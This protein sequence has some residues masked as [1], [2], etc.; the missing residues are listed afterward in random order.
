MIAE[1]RGQ[2]SDVRCQMS[3]VR[4]QRSEVRGQRSEVRGQ[5]SEARGQK[6]ARAGGMFPLS[7]LRERGGG[8]GG[9]CDFAQNDVFSG[10]LRFARNDGF[11]LCALCVLCG[12]SR[13]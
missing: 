2:M 3:E 10:L 11:F 8:E 9:F 4:G 12:E 7:R 1:V 6:R 13:F 5:R